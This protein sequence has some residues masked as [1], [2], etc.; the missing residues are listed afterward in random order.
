MQP[1]QFDGDDKIRSRIIKFL[2][3][4]DDICVVVVAIEVVDSRA[5]K[6]WLFKGGGVPFGLI[7]HS[8]C[9][10]A[11]LGGEPGELTRNAKIGS[12]NAAKLEFPGILVSG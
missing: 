9:L 3:D 10:K 7:D 4:R 12:R 11:G 2:K 5:T 6:L 1:L 8:E